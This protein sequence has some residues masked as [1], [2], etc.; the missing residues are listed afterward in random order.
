MCILVYLLCTKFRFNCSE[1]HKEKIQQSTSTSPTLK[2]TNQPQKA[3]SNV[4]QS[5][6]QRRFSGV[7][8]VSPRQKPTK[9]T[10]SPKG[11]GPTVSMIHG[12]YCLKRKQVRNNT[13]KV[14]FF[15]RTSSKYASNET[16]IKRSKT[17]S[18]T[19]QIIPCLSRTSLRNLVKVI[20]VG[21][22]F[23]LDFSLS[24]RGKSLARL[25]MWVMC[26]PCRHAVEVFPATWKSHRTFPSSFFKCQT[27]LT[28]GVP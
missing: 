7:F 25:A 16:N 6:P 15:G 21:T 9:P 2:S 13:L 12:T 1:Q 11:P 28:N 10:A 26:F 22:S 24:N 14:D 18:N 4:L 8:L 5:R 23:W 20:N 17:I 3:L 19:S 27:D